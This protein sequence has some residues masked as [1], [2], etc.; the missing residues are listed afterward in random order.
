MK[1]IAL[2]AGTFDPFT[3]GHQALL[4]RALPLFDKIIVA[5]GTNSGK[6]CLNTVEERLETIKNLFADNERIEVTSYTGLTMDFAR[7]KGA[8]VLLRGVRSAKDFEYE[9]EI[10]DVNL[11]MGGID[12]VLMM[13]EPEYA[14]VSSSIV[15]ELISYGKD[16]TSLLPQ[17]KNEK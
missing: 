5:I 10:A 9:R 15:R 14:S 1:R 12:T 6:Q 2:F 17:Q 13:C 4:L 11:K 3:R 7:E 16:V 8:T